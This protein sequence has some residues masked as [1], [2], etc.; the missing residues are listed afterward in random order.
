MDDSTALTVI[1]LEVQLQRAAELAA[2]ALSPNTQRAYRADFNHFTT[3]C[4]LQQL[5]PLHCSPELICAYLASMTDTLKTSTIARRLTAIGQAYELAGQDNP[6]HHPTVRK[7]MQGIRRTYGKKQDGVL[8]L[9][10]EDIL[11]MCESIEK[12][13]SARS[14]RD[15]A[16]LMIGFAGGFRRSELVGLHVEDLQFRRQGVVI[17]IRQSKTDQ[18]GE[19][20]TFG[21]HKQAVHCPV[22]AI[23]HYLD[24]AQIHSGPVFRPIDR[25]GNIKTKALTPQS[26]ALIIKKYALAAGLDPKDYSGHSLRSGLATQAAMNGVSERIIMK[27]TGHKTTTM[28][29]RY[30]RDGQMFDDNASKSLF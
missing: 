3:W 9:M 12:D 2:D 29:R 5:D 14:L 18:E 21:I 22:R 11:A 16:L 4:T 20:R 23:S 17:T 24:V 10:S 8:P 13:Q 15:E 27:T 28:V 6:A 19:G 26:V 25:H 7:V 1:P 30:I